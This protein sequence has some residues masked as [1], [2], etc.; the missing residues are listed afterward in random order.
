[1]GGCAWPM[2]PLDMPPRVWT[3]RPTRMRT[4]LE[5]RSTP[6]MLTPTMC[7]RADRFEGVCHLPSVVI[8][9]ISTNYEV[10]GSGPPLLMFSPGGFNATLVNWNVQG[11]FRQ[12]GLMKH[13]PSE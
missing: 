5:P 9:G 11:V 8:D 13:L 10:V 12:L 3:R 6:S 4:S 7:G 2:P 1:M